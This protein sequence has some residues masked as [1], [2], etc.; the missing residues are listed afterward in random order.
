MPSA[1]AVAPTSAT[2][3]GT[4]RRATPEA[5]LRCTPYATTLQE[6]EHLGRG[7]GRPA[8]RYGPGDQVR[9]AFYYGW[10]PSGFN[11]P[12][13]R[14]N[15]SAGRYSTEDLGT[16]QRQ[17]SQM[18][19]S[20]TKAA[21]ASWW[22]PETVPDQY[23]DYQASLTDRSLRVGPKA[24]EGSPFTWGIYYEDEAAANP[25]V[26]RIRADLDY[27]KS[28]YT[29]HPK[30]LYRTTSRSSSCGPAVATP[31]RWST[32][33]SRPL[34]TSTWCTTLH[35]LGE[36]PLGAGLL[37]PVRP[38][39]SGREPGRVLVLGLS[40]LLEVRRAVAAA[41]PRPRRFD[42]AVG[43]SRASGAPWQL[44][45]TFNEWGEGTAVEPAAEWQS[46]SGYGGALDLLRRHYGGFY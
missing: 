34:L 27:L 17:I 15:P 23:A 24:A 28:R 25:S 29:N 41:G 39:R 18:R 7:P 33:G 43:R 11:I 1:V 40:R 3:R 12:G 2:Q 36:L 26:S 37:A 42:A 8:A 4:S 16:V 21:I 35:R 9:A 46:G 13:T 20:G 44:V 6:R 31:A 32:A 14:F 22:G 5:P 38:G 30:F 10:F 19:Y 45:T